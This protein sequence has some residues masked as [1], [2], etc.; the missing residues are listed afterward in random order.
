MNC[1]RCGN[2]GMGVKVRTCVVCKTGGCARCSTGW[3]PVT[4]TN[5]YSEFACSDRC[6]YQWCLRRLPHYQSDALARLVDL[7]PMT[8]GAQPVLNPV[9]AQAA[10]MLDVMLA[11]QL[12]QQGRFNDA[13]KI[14]EFYMMEPDHQ[15]VLKLMRDQIE[16]YLHSLMTMRKDVMYNCPKCGYNIK[17]TTGSKLSSLASCMFCSALIDPGHLALFLK[18]VVQPTLR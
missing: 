15:R 17:I 2:S 4:Q 7:M 16:S 8:P 1:P 14:Y 10:R 13:A 5:K 6:M 3:I 12:E 11:Q 9:S 18:N